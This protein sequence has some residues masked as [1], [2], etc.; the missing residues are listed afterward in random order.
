M[1]LIYGPVATASPMKGRLLKLVPGVRWMPHD[2][3]AAEASEYQQKPHRSL[4][5]RKHHDASRK[6]GDKEVVHRRK[7][8]ISIPSTPDPE[9]DART[10]LQGQSTFFASLP[11]EIRKMVYEYV[12]GEETIH[13]TL[14]MKK[15][16][17]HFICED[18][19]AEQD[20][21]SLQCTCKVLV[22]GRSC[23]KLHG[24]LGMLRACRRMYTEAIPHLYAP[25]TFSLLH[26]THL[27]YLPKRV[28]FPR[29]DTIRKL[30]VRW[31]IRALPYLRRPTDP[32]R[33]A[34]PEDTTN[35]QHGWRIMSEMKGLRDLYVVVSD[36]SP[37]ALW[38]DKWL[39][40]E[41]K[42]YED[43]AKVKQVRWGEVF[44]PY[45]SCNIDVQ[46]EGCAIGFRKPAGEEE[47]DDG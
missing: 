35:W 46:F 2:I 27:L 44:L 16:L 40:L 31:S 9:L 21:E 36:P 28:P 25:H 11:L 29:L 30:R 14:G 39:A 17:G 4:F 7:S 45:A 22:G 42:L 18:E 20:E 15:K 23:R 43:I 38:E 32:K 41:D 13:M 3:P 37:Q 26:V 33:Y 8:T 5:S 19:Q 34:Y 6:R 10:H 24:P 1:P 47:E 12:M